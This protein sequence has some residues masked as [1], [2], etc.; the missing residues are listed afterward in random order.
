MKLL[1]AFFNAVKSAAKS[2]A[3]AAKTVATTATKVAQTVSKSASK[4]A[5][6][7]L[8]L[9][10]IIAVGTATMLILPVILPAIL[11]QTSNIEQEHSQA[12]ELLPPSKS[13]PIKQQEII[14][15][16]VLI[17]PISDE[18]LLIQSFFEQ[19]IEQPTNEIQEVAETKLKQGIKPLNNQ[20][21]L[22]TICWQTISETAKLLDSI[23]ASEMK[24]IASELQIPKY[25]SMNK[26]QLL[27]EIV[28]AHEHA[29]EFSQ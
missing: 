12:I 25:R 10:M 28:T 1:Q 21:A 11:A 29:P 8:Q 19:S 26:T 18:D 24:S 16:E 3:A 14:E 7:A 13:R 6:P 23:K 15:N 9:T 27:L 2:I 5:K 20:L 4:V 17:T 22:T